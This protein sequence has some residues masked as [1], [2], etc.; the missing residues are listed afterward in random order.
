MICNKLLV[1]FKIVVSLKKGLRNNYL[2]ILSEFAILLL[3]ISF[4]GEKIIF[5]GKNVRIEKLFILKLLFFI[6]LLLRTLNTNFL[7]KLWD[8]NKW[9]IHY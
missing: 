8:F 6:E 5:Y 9:E 2:I 7:K 3:M 1:G 4:E